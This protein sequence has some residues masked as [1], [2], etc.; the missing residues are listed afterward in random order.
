[1]NPEEIQL[2]IDSA[3][4][5]EGYYTTI[6]SYN[7]E[8]VDRPES[9][10]EDPVMSATFEAL[11]LITSRANYPIRYFS[12]VL[13][14]IF[15]LTNHSSR[16]LLADTVE[17]ENEERETITVINGANLKMRIGGLQA[18]EGITY[19]KGF[20]NLKDV[21]LMLRDHYRGK[22]LAEGKSEPHQKAK[23]IMALESSRFDYYIDK[24]EF[25][26]KGL[27]EKIDPSLSGDI[28]R[29]LFFIEDLEELLE[30]E[31]KVQNRVIETFGR[32]CSHTRIDEGLTDQ[33]MQS[34]EYFAL[35]SLLKIA[36]DLYPMVGY[37]VR[38]VLEA[39][40]LALFLF[41]PNK[42][43][44]ENSKLTKKSFLSFANSKRFLE[45]N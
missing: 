7:R 6:N 11:S 12:A 32:I 26:P 42:N 10:F 45:D 22:E 41:D 19:L 13:R 23:V 17:L 27:L 15:K 9:K 20:S 40:E 35:D 4:S 30:A 3:A 21:Y 25:T 1:M 18:L 38:E 43:D 37:S 36:H 28:Y 34:V 44:S 16:D 8:Y 33:I 29:K 2:A 5:E 24:L 31:L 14:G 39:R